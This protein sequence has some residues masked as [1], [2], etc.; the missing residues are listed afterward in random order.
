[1]ILKERFSFNSSGMSAENIEIYKKVFFEW[2]G[3]LAPGQTYEDVTM[4]MAL[5]KIASEINARAREIR[6][7]EDNTV[8]NG[9][10][11]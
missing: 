4:D 5:D 3:D 8:Y 9:L 6:R 11:D 7:R 10:D 1:M 2:R